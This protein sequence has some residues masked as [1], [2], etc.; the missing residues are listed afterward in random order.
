MCYLCP[1]FICL[2]VC[3]SRARSSCVIGC[4]APEVSQQCTYS[5]L[6]LCTACK[7]E[8]RQLRL[9]LQQSHYHIRLLLPSQHNCQAHLTRRIA[10]FV[11]QTYLALYS[12]FTR[13][14]WM[15]RLSGIGS[16]ST[17]NSETPAKL[18]QEH[19]PELHKSLIC[20][21]PA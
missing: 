18:Q 16:G 14:K 19:L 4:A 2:C 5:Y 9:A 10:C 13:C 7:V 17:P 20:L 12:H 1:Q 3:L 6:L 21:T 15:E 11:D 8:L